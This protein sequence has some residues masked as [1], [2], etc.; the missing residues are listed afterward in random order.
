M[1]INCERKWG[2]S[3]GNLEKQVS[4]DKAALT[5]S[6]GEDRVGGNVIISYVVSERFSRV[7]GN[8]LA[9]VAYQRNSMSSRNRLVMYPCSLCRLLAASH[10]NHDLGIKMIG[11]RAHGLGFPCC[12]RSTKKYFQGHF[13]SLEKV[14]FD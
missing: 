9:K 14:E 8:L 2:R 12:W 3:L 10:E 5:L 11:F 7:L 1:E 6:E 4:D 13:S